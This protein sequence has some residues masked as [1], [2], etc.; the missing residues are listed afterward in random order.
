MHIDAKNMSQ[1]GQLDVLVRAFEKFA[2]RNELR[3]D[4]WAEYN[5]GDSNHHAEHKLARVKR[6]CEA[7]AARPEAL[8]PEI[9]DEIV[10]DCLD[11]INYVTFTVRHVHAGRI[12]G[13]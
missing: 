13:Q 5:T 6:L 3:N 12:A 11:L 9:V 8:T 4:L 2:E 1:E 10:D 7:V